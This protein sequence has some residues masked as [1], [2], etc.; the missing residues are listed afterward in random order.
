MLAACVCMLLSLTAMAEENLIQNAG[1]E[2]ASGEWP[3][4]WQSDMWVEDEGV[5]RITL[6]PEGREGGRCIRIENASRN[7]A[8]VVQNIRIEPGS[9]YRLSGWVLAD[10][11]DPSQGGAGFSIMGSASAFPRVYDTAGA[12]EELVCYFETYEGQRDVQ[13]AARLGFYGGEAKG[14]AYF[15]DLSIRR[16]DEAPPGA[17]V[18]RLLDDTEYQKPPRMQDKAWAQGI[19]LAAV[20]LAALSATALLLRTH[21]RK[22][23]AGRL[24]G[25]EGSGT[26]RL[27]F[28]KREAICLLCLTGIYAV[29]AFMDLGNL[30]AAQTEWKSTQDD[31]RVVFDLGAENTFRILYNEGLCSRD[32]NLTFRFSYDG[33]TWSDP[34]P[35]KMKKWESFQW[36]FVTEPTH[37]NAGE[38]SGWSEEPIRFHARYVEMT[39][40]TPGASLLEIAFVDAE[41]NALSVSIAEGMPDAQR[42]VDEQEYVPD[43]PGYRNSMYFDEIYHG[44]TAYEHAHA[45]AAQENSHPPLGKILIMLGIELF[46]MT[47][48]G[49]RFSGALAGICMIPAMYLLGKVLFGQEKYAFLSA[50]LLAFDMMHLTQTRIATIDSYPVLFI[51]LMYACMIRYT[52][53]SFFTDGWHTLVP[54][55]LSGLFMG[56]GIASKWTGI[57]AGVGLAALFFWSLARRACEWRAACATGGAYAMRAG[58]FSK[59]AMGTL[60]CCLIFF[61]AIPFAIY[62]LSYI[63]HFT[64]AQGLTWERFWNEQAQ[65]LRYHAGQADPH[66][67]QSRWFE[68]P[69]MLRPMWYYTDPYMPQGQVSTIVCM[70]NPAVW[71]PGVLALAYTLWAWIRQNV[72]GEARDPRAAVV[73][74][75]FTAQMLPWVFVT[76]STFIYHYF[77]SLIFIILSL[78][79]AWERIGTAHPRAER[80][81]LPCYMTGVLVLFL[82]FYPFGTGYAMSRTYA[83]AMNWLRALRVPW[84]SY[85]GWLGY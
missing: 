61:I 32:H 7:D 48:F 27:V 37:N 47:P 34:A 1:F 38:I 56:L 76:R 4:A 62:Y 22:A 31:Q 60:G 36:F 3:D 13:V 45:L 69:L 20:A 18:I 15:D 75:G 71:W 81:L 85:G 23:R 28:S 49:W 46:G 2:A 11:L 6:M 79:Y 29:F 35:A 83:D 74:I 52:Q 26:P 43:R 50:F 73:L 44:R 59:Y 72:C 68:W 58:S 41:G 19:K 42:L 40:D 77:P 39:A 51:I 5:T 54:L 57:Y 8:R 82:C 25:L 84:R 66:P 30:K 17:T 24:R 55:A 9:L 33:E 63:P 53:M 67:Y 21:Q 64:G 10:G 14:T 16:V 70:G 78:V 12:W 65:M 80:A